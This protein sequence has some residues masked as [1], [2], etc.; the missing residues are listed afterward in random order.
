MSEAAR[1]AAARGVLFDKDG[2]L[3]AVERRRGDL[4]E[5]MIHALSHGDARLA[6]QLA[7][8]G[9]YDLAAGAYRP[10]SPIASGAAFDLAEAWAATLPLWEAAELKTWIELE[11]ASEAKLGAPALAADLPAL[12]DRLAAA[13]LALGVATHALESGTRRQ[14]ERAGVADRFA[15]IAGIDSGFAPKPD[16]SML[17]GFCAAAALDP[18]AVVVVGDGVADLRMARAGGALAAIGVL[19]GGAAPAT[20]TEEAD[21]VLPTID[22]LPDALGAPALA[23]AGTGAEGGR[24]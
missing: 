23:R 22:D 13:G 11:Q 18:S 8:L 21:L 20:L 3:F 10:G 2:T 1:F 6:R 7:A 19:S 15:F 14:L 4:A 24:P 5:R 17:R 9:G 16:A 12:L